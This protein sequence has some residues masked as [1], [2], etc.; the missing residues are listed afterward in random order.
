MN[1][2]HATF[3]WTDQAAFW[4]TSIVVEPVA[5]PYSL[6]AFSYRVEWDF[7]REV[8]TRDLA[9]LRRNISVSAHWDS[10]HHCALQPTGFRSARPRFVGLCRNS[11]YF[12]SNGKR[13]QSSFCRYNL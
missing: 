6:I 8:L 9:Y 3:T 12:S 5:E 10:D 7:E 2:N 13:W 11:N 4:P 1:Q